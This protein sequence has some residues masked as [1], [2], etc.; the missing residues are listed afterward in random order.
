[1]FREV[2]LADPDIY[3]RQHITLQFC[4]VGLLMVAGIVQ[5]QAEDTSPYC[6][7]DQCEWTHKPTS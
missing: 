2:D 6:Y 5:S 1:M 7:F 3:A 4:V